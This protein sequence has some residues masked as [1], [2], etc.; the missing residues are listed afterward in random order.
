M[1]GRNDATLCLGAKLGVAA[2]GKGGIAGEHESHQ[3][4][5]PSESESLLDSAMRRFFATGLLFTLREGC[6]RSG[7]F[8]F[9]AGW[10]S[11]VGLPVGAVL[12]ACGLLLPA[13]ALPGFFNLSVF[14]A[15]VLL[16]KSQLSME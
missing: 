2:R 15:E 6:A 9:A 7:F 14:H 16:E 4:A 5:S 1:L 11:G 13:A 10:D 3:S 8:P 12:D